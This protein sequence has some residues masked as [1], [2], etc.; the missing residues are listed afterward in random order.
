MTGFMDRRLFA[1]VVRR[2][3]DMEKQA[4]SLPRKEAELLH[5][6][7]IR[8]REKVNSVS[9]E[10]EKGLLSSRGSNDI[11]RPDQCDWAWRPELWMAPIHPAGMVGI[12][13]P[14]QL[15]E[16]VTAFHDCVNSEIS[17]R[18]QRS[19]DALDPNG[20]FLSLDVYRFDGGFLSLVLSPAHGAVQGL[21]RNHYF[22]LRMQ[23]Q[24]EN[25]LEVFARLNIQHGPNTEQVV[26]QLEFNGESG[27]AEFDLAYSNINGKRLENLWIDVIF[28]GPQ[29]TQVTVR[30]LTLARAPRADL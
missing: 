17:V 15:S 26:R 7:M 9:L 6:R 16:T 14:Y 25:P 11:E 19:A 23:M 13:S 12:P 1:R 20:F 8:L 27:L 5:S 21:T 18:Q 29:M 2:L 10:A 24:R 28:E 3:A 22:S 30:A 4:A